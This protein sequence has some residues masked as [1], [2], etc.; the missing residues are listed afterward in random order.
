MKLI[1]YLAISFALLSA[2]CEQA[3]CADKAVVESSV[4]QGIRLSDKARA[5][6][7]IQNTRLTW[8]ISGPVP[9]G[10]LV[11][12]QDK[13]GVYRHRKGWF[14]LVEVSV[15]SVSASRVTIR[16]EDLDTG[17]DVVVSGVA[18]LRV[19]DMQAFGGGE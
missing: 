10:S 4:S 2:S 3:C 17:D 14:K 16:S 13:V 6:L 9:A 15:I 12:Y 5:T 19:A 7:A 1:G 18:L 11:H 8:R